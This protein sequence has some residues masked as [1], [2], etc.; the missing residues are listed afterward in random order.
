MYSKPYCQ[1]Q[2]LRD[3][4]MRP[5]LDQTSKQWFGYWRL[6]KMRSGVN[7]EMVVQSGRDASTAA[8]GSCFMLSLVQG[9]GD[10]EGEHIP[11]HQSAI[12][13]RRLEWG[14]QIPHRVRRSD[15]TPL[16]LEDL[17]EVIQVQC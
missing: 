1:G 6:S 3:W 7:S 4:I 8:F 12:A 16:L 17:G 10:E 13:R 9:A 5:I 2:F 15:Q 14:G 11:E